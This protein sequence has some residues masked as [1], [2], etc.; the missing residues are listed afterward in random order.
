MLMNGAQMKVIRQKAESLLKAYV[1]F[2]YGDAKSAAVCPGYSAGAGTTCG[3][4]CHWLMWRLGVKDPTRVNWNDPGRGLTAVSGQN[5]ARI[6]QQGHDPFF[7]CASTAKGAKKI[8]PMV[9]GFRPQL[10]D[11]VFLFEPGGGQS[12]EHVF[13]FM[14]EELHGSSIYW[15]SAEAGQPGALGSTDSRMRRRRIILPTGNNAL[16]SPTVVDETK[17]V[18]FDLRRDTNRAIIGW[19]DVGGLDYIDTAFEDAKKPVEVMA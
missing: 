8:N 7:V 16:M 2:K 19:L 9:M 4:L 13:V 12:S 1:P 6:Y 11:I 14:S 3:Y 17:E 10:G 5:I 18:T 15:N